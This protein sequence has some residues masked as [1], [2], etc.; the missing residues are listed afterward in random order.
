MQTLMDVLTA[1]NKLYQTI[2]L[3][4][5]IKVSNL[6][7]ISCV[8]AVKFLLES[9]RH[10]NL[11]LMLYLHPTCHTTQAISLAYHPF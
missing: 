2:N 4:S 6:L 11:V 5:F 1:D 7:W 3:F 10:A 8:I 9:K